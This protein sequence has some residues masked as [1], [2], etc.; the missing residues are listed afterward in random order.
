MGKGAVA[1]TLFSIGHSNHDFGR[2][3][4]LLRPYGIEVV[5]DVRSRPHSRHVPHFSKDQLAKR[6]ADEGLAYA[7]L[8]RELGGK[9]P[10]DDPAPVRRSFAERAA[11]P[12]FQ[13]G[14]AH[15]LEQAGER[16]VAMLCRERDPLDCHRFHLIGRHL[17][18]RVVIR[19]ILPDG[20][21]EDHAGTEQR[22][23]AREGEGA[24]PLF[25]G[26]G[27]EAAI[28]RAYDAAWARF[29]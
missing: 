25:A 11:E 19:H 2:L 13:Q 10:R 14:I 1:P 3:L 22:L 7:Y 24:L 23:L 27:D 16:S 28:L 6:L 8:G 20:Q 21:F 15:L 9:P 17:R 29:R 5:A 4:A 26:E 18:G 12:A